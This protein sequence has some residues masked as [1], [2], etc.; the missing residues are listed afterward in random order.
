MLLGSGNHQSLASCIRSTVALPI[1]ITLS[2]FL[3]SPL[4]AGKS[5]MQVGLEALMGAGLMTHGS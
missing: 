3:A 5:P 1:A 2:A 4:V